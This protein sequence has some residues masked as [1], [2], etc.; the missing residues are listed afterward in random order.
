MSHPH[1]RKRL[2]C[3]SYESLYTQSLKTSLNYE[4][5]PCQDLLD[6]LKDRLADFDEFVRAAGL[7]LNFPSRFDI[8]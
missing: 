2:D 3:L 7:R 8:D 5:R 6:N 4:L 1:P